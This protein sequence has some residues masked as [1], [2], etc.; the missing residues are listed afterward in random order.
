MVAVR[1]HAT[2]GYSAVWNGTRNTTS[3]GLYKADIIRV[4]KPDGSYKLVGRDKRQAGKDV[5]RESPWMR[6][7]KKLGYFQKGCKFTPLPK[8][9]SA[10]YNEICREADYM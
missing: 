5:W 9:G 6:A 8:K 4:K 7:A 1:R 10:A 3:G 2:A